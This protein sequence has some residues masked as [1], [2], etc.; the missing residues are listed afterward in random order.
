MYRVFFVSLKLSLMSLQTSWTLDQGSWRQSWQWWQESGVLS[1]PPWLWVLCPLERHQLH[2]PQQRSKKES[3]HL[4]GWG[5]C[6]HHPPLSLGGCKHRVWVTIVSTDITLPRRIKRREK[7]IC[8][9][10]A[11]RQCQCRI[12]GPDSCLEDGTAAPSCCNSCSQVS[13][14]TE[15]NWWYCTQQSREDAGVTD[16]AKMMIVSR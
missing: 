3:W 1:P 12:R 13:L 15:W 11:L 16:R 4:L 10:K 14:W 8:D 7:L 9:E 6:T 2:W 5:H